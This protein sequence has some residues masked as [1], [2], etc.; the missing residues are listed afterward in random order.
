M[1][2]YLTRNNLHLHC[3]A[4]GDGALAFCWAKSEHP[5][6][7]VSNPITPGIVRKFLKHSQGKHFA[8]KNYEIHQIENRIRLVAPVRRVSKDTLQINGKIYVYTLNPAL[9]ENGKLVNFDAFHVTTQVQGNTYYPSD[10]VE[11]KNYSTLGELR[12]FLNHE[13]ELKPL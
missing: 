8:Q 2:R 3:Y 1:L 9:I 4:P 10:V 5:Y 11:V 12:F 7:T 13:H 6:P